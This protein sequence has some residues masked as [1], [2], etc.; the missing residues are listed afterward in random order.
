MPVTDE[1]HGC[2]IT[3][4]TSAFAGVLLAINGYAFSRPSIETSKMST[5]TNH[6]FMPADLVD[7]GEIE[8]EF[9]FDPSLT[10][11]IASAAET[12]T[13][14]FPVP[15]GLST[16]STWAASA[17]MTNYAPSAISGQRMPATAPLKVSGAVTITPAA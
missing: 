6:T 10:P 3:F 14:T 4:G 15:S 9:E 13:I 12:V 11:P 8:L 1:G 2:S 5:T 16:G 17:F 7:R